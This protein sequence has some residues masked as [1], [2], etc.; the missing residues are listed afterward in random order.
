MKVIGITGGVGSGKSL[1]LDYL[2]EQFNFYVIQADFVAHDLQRPGKIC[3]HAI[4]TE[5]GKDIL[6][7]TGEIN[8]K[9]L[10]D[11]VFQDEEKL[12]RLNEITHPLVKQEIL[13]QIEKCRLQGEKVVFLE[14]ALLIEAGYDT[15]C[16]EL[17]YIFV[18]TETR[19][20]RLIK[21]RGYSREKAMDIIARQLS[22][23]QFLEKCDRIIDNNRTPEYCYEQI[24]KILQQ[25]ELA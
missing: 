5:F 12:H 10:G 15:I 19:I 3:Y 24:Q 11:V 17:W 4:V 7:D 6:D 13:S 18:E 1:V 20:Q 9:K 14:A 22:H 25:E 16:H 8:R 23:R 2:K 21:S